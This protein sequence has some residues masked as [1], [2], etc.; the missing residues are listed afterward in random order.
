MSTTLLILYG[1]FATLVLGLYFLVPRKYRYII[2]LVASLTF[3]AIYSKF[4]IAFILATILSIYFAGLGMNKLDDKLAK[5]IAEGEFDKEQKKALKA[6]NKKKKKA[7]LVVAIL[8]NL[9][10]LAV[11]K[12]SGFFASIFEGIF[13]WFSVT[14][15][16]PVLKLALP[17]GISYYTLSSIGYM[18]DVQRGKYRADKNILKVALFVCYFPQLFEGPFAKYDELAPQLYEG[19]DFDAKRVFKGLLLAIWGLLKKIVIADRLAI[20]ASE[21]FANYAQYNG[22]VIVFGIICFTF[23]LYAE[24]SGLI[25]MA[26][27]I[28]EMFGIKLTKNFDQPFFSQNVNEFWRRWHISLGTWFKEYIFYPISMSKGMMNLNKKMHGKVKPFFELFI[29]SALALFVV[30]FTNGLWHGASFQYVLYGLYYYLI[31]MIGMCLEPLFN[32]IYE[33]T[34]INKDSKVMVVLRILR[35]FVL[36]N[37]GML[38]FRASS[39]TAF[40]EMFAQIFSGGDISIVGT[41]IIDWHDFVLCLLG[42]IVLIVVDVFKER[43]V[44]FREKLSNKHFAIKALVCVAIV[45]VV[46]VFGAFGGEYIPPDPIYG[47]F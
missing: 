41:G 36:V 42:I 11:L 21:V 4:M 32:K 31:M 10:I 1:V 40:G 37:I 6:K 8:F 23:Q 9:A 34:K 43:K 39:I 13:S 5:T 30:W 3:F 18:V 25:D 26:S 19:H 22:I 24:F 38:L 46:L 17:L 29:P 27:G 35:T 2:I 20:I 15:S 33:K 47:G 44:D 16:F 14:T 7:I 28:S 12:Y 45:V